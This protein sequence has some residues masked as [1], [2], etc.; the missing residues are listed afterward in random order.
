MLFPACSAG[1]DDP[2]EIVYSAKVIDESGRV[3]QIHARMA[4]ETARIIVVTVDAKHGNV[5][6][7]EIEKMWSGPR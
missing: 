2:Y 7:L 3:E 1:V 6:V 5:H 4:P